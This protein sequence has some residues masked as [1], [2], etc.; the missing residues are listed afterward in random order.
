MALRRPLVT[1]GSAAIG[2]GLA[3]VTCGALVIGARVDPDTTGSGTTGFR[4]PAVAGTWFRAT[5]NDKR[6]DN[7]DCVNV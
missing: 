3:D 5:G 6:T 4:V 1:S 7:S 2:N